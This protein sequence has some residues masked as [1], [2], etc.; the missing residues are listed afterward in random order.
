MTGDHEDQ[1]GQGYISIH[2]VSL[3]LDAAES[4]I[5]KRVI[6]SVICKILRDFSKN[7][8]IYCATLRQSYFRYKIKIVF[9]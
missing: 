2:P 5:Y 9:K 4:N 6:Y 1:V 3:D 8:Q 7:Y